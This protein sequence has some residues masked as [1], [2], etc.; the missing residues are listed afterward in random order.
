MK[1][2]LENINISKRKLFEEKL[3]YFSHKTDGLGKEIEPGIIEQVTYLN[4]LGFHTS[5]SCE[6]HI[7]GWAYPFGYILFGT[8]NE[9]KSDFIINK[10]DNELRDN[11]FR[12][13]KERFPEF[14]GSPETYSQEIDDFFFK[15][16]DEGFKKHPQYNEY[17]TEQVKE[18]KKIEFEKNK[19]INLIEDF[20]IAFP[21]YGDKIYI[22]K[23]LASPNIYF[24]NEAN[25]QLFYNNLIEKEPR[26]LETSQ[27][28]SIKTMT[29]FNKFLKQKYENK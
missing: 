25:Y 17:L 11:A 7:D 10:I 21:E 27:N 2:N 8:E 23:D 16:I 13:E 1:Q 6:G 3:E 15:N 22:N 18:N 5:A 24:T 19:V 12:L 20:K 29:A 14:D 9:F 4:L 28:E 26:I